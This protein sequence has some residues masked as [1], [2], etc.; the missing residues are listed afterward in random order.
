MGDD[1]IDMTDTVSEESGGVAKVRLQL[2]TRKWYVSK[3]LPKIFGDRVT[4]EH[5]GKDG[6]PIETRELDPDRKLNIARRL[7]VFLNDL[8]GNLPN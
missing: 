8:D 1:L 5:V 7:A 3:A 2:D 6:G 4:N